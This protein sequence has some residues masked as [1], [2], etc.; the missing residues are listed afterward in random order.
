MNQKI[1]GFPKKVGGKGNDSEKYEK[2]GTWHT[3]H[4]TD[5]LQPLPKYTH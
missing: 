2:I 4:Y 1:G 3:V 5:P